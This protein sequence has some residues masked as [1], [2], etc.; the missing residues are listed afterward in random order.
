MAYF[1]GLSVNLNQKESFQG[2]TIALLFEKGIVSNIDTE[3]S[4]LSELKIKFSSEYD[5]EIQKIQE[6]TN[7]FEEL[8]EQIENAHKEQEKQFGELLDRGRS[9]LQ[10]IEDIYNKKLALQS[11]V[12]GGPLFLTGGIVRFHCE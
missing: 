12:C 7:Q 11:S 9:D 4:S 1:V 10:Q 3:K 6:L 5:I 2:Y 8:K